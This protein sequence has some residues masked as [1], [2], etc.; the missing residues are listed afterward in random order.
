MRQNYHCT[1]LHSADLYMLAAPVNGMVK[2]GAAAAAL[3]RH[4]VPGIPATR[5]AVVESSRNMPLTMA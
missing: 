1:Q 4:S 3:S 5:R 2:A